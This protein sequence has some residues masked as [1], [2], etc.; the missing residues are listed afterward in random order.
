[1]L[2]DKDLSD[3]VAQVYFT[4]LDKLCTE[5]F[6]TALDIGWNSKHTSICL[7]LLA[8]LKTGFDSLAKLY[9]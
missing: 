3:L 6:H 4:V 8:D 7:L 2:V 5:H 1:M 9:E